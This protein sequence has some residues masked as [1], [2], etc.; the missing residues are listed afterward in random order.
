MLGSYASPGLHRIPVLKFFDQC[1]L[2]Y[3]LHPNEMYLVMLEHHRELLLHLEASVLPAVG[4]TLS[5]STPLNTSRCYLLLGLTSLATIHLS[6][7]L[8]HPES[9]VEV[10]HTRSILLHLLDEIVLVLFLMEIA[11]NQSTLVAPAFDVTSHRFIV[12][13]SGLFADP[14]P[15]DLLTSSLGLSLQLLLSLVLLKLLEAPVRGLL[16]HLCSP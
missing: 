8:A 9:R 2:L 4:P 5:K 6:L 11:L 16:G 14:R 13:T 1:S 15:D 7:P 12:G 3:Q 10:A